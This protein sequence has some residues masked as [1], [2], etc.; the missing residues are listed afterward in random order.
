MT[1]AKIVNEYE[2]EDITP[3]VIREFFDCNYETGELWW[4]WRARKWF[5]SDAGQKAAN[6]RC[7]GKRAFSAMC[8]HKYFHAKFLGFNFKAHRVVW[9]H[10][11]GE[12]PE[13]EID[14]IRGVMYGDGIANLRDVSIAV[15]RQNQKRR[16]DNSSGHTGIHK[17][18]RS[19]KWM[20][21]ITVAGTFIN[22]GLHAQK[23]DAIAARKAAER[24]YGFSEHHGRDDDPL[25][26]DGGVDG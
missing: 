4:K 26:I 8:K 13:G 11:Y 24:E 25:G 14:H 18:K 17:D 15:N 21:H 3:E 23:A 1:I 9:A 19:G 2:R 5:K 20:A 7:A 12:W 6:S 10:Y 22:L 16:A